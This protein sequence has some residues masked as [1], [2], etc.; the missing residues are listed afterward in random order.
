MYL[1]GNRRW[2][3]LL[4]HLRLQLTA[5]PHLKLD[6]IKKGIG[7]TYPCDLKSSIFSKTEL[8][9]YS[10]FCTSICNG[11][12]VRTTGSEEKK[13]LPL[14][15]SGGPKLSIYQLAGFVPSLLI[16]YISFS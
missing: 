16:D 8:I 7:F 4:S 3:P 6:E 2:V 10:R 14:K 12:K 11:C 5:R 1:G 15:Y 9:I 13:T